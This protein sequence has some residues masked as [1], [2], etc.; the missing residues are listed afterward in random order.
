[1]VNTTAD[2]LTNTWEDKADEREGLHTPEYLEAIETSRQTTGSNIVKRG[3]APPGRGKMNNGLRDREP[4]NGISVDRSNMLRHIVGLRY[5]GYSYREAFQDASVKYEIKPH[6]VE[7]YYYNHSKEVDLVEQEHLE[8][9]L[10]SYHNHLW[11]IRSMMSDAGPRAVRTLIGVMDDKKSSPNIRLKAAAYILKM[12]NADGSAS[13][14]PSE[15]AAVESLKLIK[16][17][18]EGIQEEKESHIIDAVQ[19]DDAEIIGDDE[20][21][22]R[23]TVAV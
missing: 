18:R 3:P 14:N 10:K 22:D 5:S 6:S 15:H 20:S 9:A 2:S 16:D 8:Y 21:E 7:N 4:I 23:P 1:L 13:S 11:A 19:A 12:V 17:M